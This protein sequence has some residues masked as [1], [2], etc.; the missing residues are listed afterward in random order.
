MPASAFVVC[1]HA[2]RSPNIASISQHV[3]KVAEPS[4]ACGQHMGTIF[5]AIIDR[6]AIRY[7][8]TCRTNVHRIRRHDPAM[9]AIQQRAGHDA[10]MVRATS[11]AI[12]FAGLTIAGVHMAGTRRCLVRRDAI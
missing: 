7:A 1:A 5:T 3:P 11:H 4:P 9:Y 10:A 2:V 8:S 6:K 12:S